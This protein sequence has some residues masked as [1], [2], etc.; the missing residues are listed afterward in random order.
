MPKTT[1]PK[2]ARVPK[3]ANTS[4]SSMLDYG[5]YILDLVMNGRSEQEAYYLVFSIVMEETFANKKEFEEILTKKTT[6]MPK[7]THNAVAMTEKASEA[8]VTTKNTRPSYVFS[9]DGT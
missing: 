7:V 6:E 2:T 3:T 5:P 1:N 9:A 8:P 4:Q